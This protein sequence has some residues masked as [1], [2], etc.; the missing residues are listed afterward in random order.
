VEEYSLFVVLLDYT[1]YRGTILVLHEPADGNA[2]PEEGREGEEE[3][4]RHRG[5]LQDSRAL[6]VSRF[7]AVGEGPACPSVSPGYTG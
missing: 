3:A 4:P 2:N 7:A 5:G 1:Q 6:P